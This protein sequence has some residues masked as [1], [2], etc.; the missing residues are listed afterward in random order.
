[1]RSQ[2]LPQAHAQVWDRG[3][4]RPGGRGRRRRAAVPVDAIPPDRPVGVRVAPTGPLQ[5]SAPAPAFATH[6]HAGLILSQVLFA[7][8]A[9]VG[10]IL[11]RQLP[12]LALVTAR[13]GGA[14][15]VFAAVALSRRRMRFSRRELLRLALCGL[16]G[17]AMNQLCFVLGLALTSA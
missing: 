3:G 8:W 11:L 2:V 5:R 6:T 9:V 15:L 1:H 17:V 4:R 16:F 10:K 7:T 12:P 14:A 13:S